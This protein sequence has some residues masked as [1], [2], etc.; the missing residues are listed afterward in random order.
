MKA[1]HIVLLSVCTLLLLA[2]FQALGTAYAYRSRMHET[3]ATLASVFKNAFML[4][5]DAQVNRLPYP[6]GTITHLVYVPD[7]LHQNDE[8]RQLYF[9]EQTSTIMQDAY[10]QPEI[11]LDSLRRQLA[12]FLRHEQVEGSVFIRKFD[13]RTG[14]TLGTS[15]AGADLPQAGIGILVSPRTFIHQQKGLAVEAVLD[16]HYFSH[17]A[18]LLFPGLTLLLALLLVGAIV[19]RLRLLNR[20]QHDID[21]QCADYYRLAEEM[22]QPVRTMGADLQAA[23]WT[24]AGET[25]RRVLADT[26]AVLTRAKQENA[27]RRSRRTRWLGSLSWALMPLAL[28]LPAL[29]GAFV[30]HGQ[31]KALG[32]TAEVALERA[33]MEEN[34]LRYHQAIDANHLRGTVKPWYTGET[35]FYRRQ[36]DSLLQ[37]VFYRKIVNEKGDT[38]YQA[39]AG[40][41]LNTIFVL[42]KTMNLSEG[43]RLYRAYGTQETVNSYPVVVPVD[44]LRLDSLFRVE[45]SRA[46]LPTAAGLR[47]FRPAT[48]D[49]VTQTGDATPRRGSLVTAPLRLDEEGAVCVQGV[50]PRPQGHIFRSAWYLYVPLGLTAVFCI[51]CIAGL[52]HVWRRRR[53]LEQ[54]RKDFTYS[55][56]HDMKSPLQS[57]LMGTQ[58][59]AGGRLAD[60]PDK[61]A[62]IRTALREECAHLLS[63]SAR[64]VTLTQMDRG[65][66]QLHLSDVPLRPLLDDLAAKFRLKAPKPVTFDIRCAEGLTARADA[67]C[68]HEVL[69]NLIDNALKYSG[70]EVRIRLAALPAADGGTCLQ[71][72]DNGIGIP[73]AERDR[74]FDRFRRIPAGSRRTGA[75]GFGLGLN[76][77]QQVVQAHGGMVT[78]ESDGCS[79]SE[80]TV[81]L[82][83]KTDGERL[84]PDR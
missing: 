12:G 24:E 26:E 7:S 28:L 66:L 81:R 42:H 53:R 6:E 69:S 22:A 40:F 54:F 2:L 84:S 71:I 56:I 51:L 43:I 55:M 82:P 18:N 52:W 65:T 67:F 79:F 45:L 30:Y 70:P 73:P 35:D 39:R 8:D 34:D 44:T 17:P 21:R 31:A 63:L 59:L 25:A 38:L 47:I 29:W 64:V 77:V 62:R 36:A 58:L 76:F 78:V 80:F 23:R 1:K 48:G 75:S 49:V 50:M 60:K 72:R 5:V 33:F 19:L 41:G 15:P 16:T 20:L 10:G 83:G 3:E 11:S 9:A 68:L 32:H 13:A 46:G 61:A 4:T 74:I 27:R 57:L 37:N 14:R